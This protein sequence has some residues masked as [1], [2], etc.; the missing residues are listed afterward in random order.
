MNGQ[1]LTALSLFSSGGIGDLAIKAAGFHIVVSNELLPD[2]H[3]VF[4]FNFPNTRSLTG[5]I[6]RLLD[7]IVEA[8][9]EALGGEE[10]TLLYATPPCQG[11]SK[12][13]RGKLLSAIRAGTKPP[14]DERNRLI[15]PTMK[16]AKRLRPE[17]V[18]LENVPEMANTL[19]VDEGGKPTQI[20]DF[21]S[22][23]LGDEYSGSAEVVE[24]ADFGV[25]QCRQRLITVFVRTNHLKTWHREL[26]TLIPPGTH[27]RDAGNCKLPW[28]TVRD[29]IGSLPPIDARDRESATS[30]IPFH[31]V[32]L[33]DE[34]KYWWV[35]NTPPNRTAFDNQCASCG[36]DKNQTHSARRNDS[37]I[38]RASRNTPVHCEKCGALLP[39]PSVVREG[40]RE[41]MRGFTSAYKRMSYDR[42]ASA[43]TR[44]LSYACSDNKIHPE[45]NR[46][47]SLYEAFQIH[48]IDRYDYKWKRVDGKK[49]SDKTIREIIGESIPPAGLQA[50]IDHL[51]KVRR[52]D[53]DKEDCSAVGPLFATSAA[54]SGGTAKGTAPPRRGGPESG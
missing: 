43:L 36:F 32:P 19:I 39:R 13:G 51:L 1:R 3:S 54:I 15:I 5:D 10:L 41:L 31:R 38:N 12:N 23:Q 27:S 8:T 30:D 20:L 46:V 17:I 21:V 14:L 6:W 7:E 44:N 2:R 24:F 35:S 28:V 52:G 9:E 34:M 22:E 33:L 26:G 49:V 37:G 16:L 48:S 25:P 50:I 42:P 53:G 29:A 4:D 40:R 47:L 18:V 45:Q 11:M